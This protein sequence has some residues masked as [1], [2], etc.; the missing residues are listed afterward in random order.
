MES[1]IQAISTV[2]KMKMILLGTDSVN[3]GR[4]N[5]IIHHYLTPETSV[6]AR[7]P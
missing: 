3:I 4:L 5:E 7:T 1:K 2:N 6:Q